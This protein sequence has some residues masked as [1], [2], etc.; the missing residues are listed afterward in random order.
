MQA[1]K[2]I[3]KQLMI[4]IHIFCLIFFCLPVLKAEIPRTYQQKFEQL[5]SEHKKGEISDKI[6]LLKADT[7]IYDLLGEGHTL[8]TAELKKLLQ[9]Y[10]KT[11]WEKP[12]Y[13]EER[14]KYFLFFIN[15]AQF[16]QKGGEAIFF[17]EKL[18]K[19]IEKNSG[20]KSLIELHEKCYF[21]IVNKSEE[22]AI[23]AFHSE[24][25][26]IYS[27]PELVS[28]NKISNEELVRFFHLCATIS[29]AYAELS[30][31]KKMEQL[32]SLMERTQRVAATIAQYDT[33]CFLNMDIYLNLV[34]F[35]QAVSLKNFQKAE[36]ALDNIQT[37]IDSNPQTLQ[38]FIP[39]IINTIHEARI[40]LYLTS[41][42]NQKAAYYI[43]QYEKLPDLGIEQQ[44][45]I[46]SNKAYLYENLKKYRL[47]YSFLYDAIKDKKLFYN[48]LAEEM[49]S[50]QYANMDA[51]FNMLA[52]QNEEISKRNRL[53]IIFIISSIAIILITVMIIIMRRRNLDIRKRI[54]NLNK[55]V[56]TGIATIEEIKDQAMKT[57]HQ[58]LG[59]ELEDSLYSS[60]ISI[61]DR[62]E[63]TD[64]RMKNPELKQKLQQI[65]PQL[66]NTL[67]QI[68]SKDLNWQNRSDVSFKNHIR[69]IIEC[70]F[71]D[72]HYDK[73][74]KLE[75]HSLEHIQPD[76]RIELL[77]IIQEAITN[78]I[79]HASARKISMMMYE[80]KDNLI[81]SIK[82]DGKGFEQKYSSN[83]SIGLKSMLERIHKIKGK[84]NIISNQNGTELIISIPA[85]N[86]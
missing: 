55:T 2:T 84:L 14:E 5:E 69:E 78:I 32:I 57:E 62:L 52:I 51:R 15:N 83:K 64:K 29:I 9:S 16:S 34:S 24:S 40:D 25:Q 17:A 59:K 3:L 47:A 43:S 53:I 63:A 48:S 36:K 50:L 13:K 77:R 72:H 35:D 54:Q 56:N 70:A 58:K 60:L 6:Y 68:K 26:F 67:L 28:E 65:I 44:F 71:P 31:H 73:D 61:K 27:F 23:E 12:E 79:K 74:V 30:Y 46:K 80:E 66:D 42:E 45:L 41:G 19:E 76:K 11:A 4:S 33:Y 21:F 7:L 86:F 8:K 1:K 22:K 10:E 39:F 18:A 37:I 38:L 49:N 20:T 82:D 85:N 81:L 75:E